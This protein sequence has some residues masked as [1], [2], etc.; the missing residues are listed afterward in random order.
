MTPAY[1]SSKT[2]SIF[3][4]FPPWLS[5]Y[6]RTVMNFLLLKMMLLYGHT[7]TLTNYTLFRAAVMEAAYVLLPVA[8]ELLYGY[9]KD[10]VSSDRGRNSFIHEN[11]CSH[12]HINI[13]HWSKT[14]RYFPIGIPLGFYVPVITLIQ[15]VCSNEFVK[16]VFTSAHKIRNLWLAIRHTKWDFNSLWCTAHCTSGMSLFRVASITPT[17]C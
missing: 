8:L 12:E 3:P 13:Y 11:T 15:A 2:I 1:S 10:R 7:C 17:C 9:N 16:Q 4:L 14:F 6:P 5:W